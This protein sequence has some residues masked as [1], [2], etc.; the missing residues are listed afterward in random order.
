VAGTNFLCTPQP[1]PPEIISDLLEHQRED[2]RKK[3]DRAGRARVRASIGLRRAYIRGVDALRFHE[4]T[5]H[6]PASV[7][8]SA[9]ALDWSNKPHPF[10]LINASH[11]QIADGPT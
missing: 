7:R 3:F 6:T 5:K 10:N 4:L 2:F 9:R 11:T 1:T 8:R